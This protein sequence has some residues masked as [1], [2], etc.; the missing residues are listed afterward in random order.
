MFCVFFHLAECSPQLQQID[1][2]ETQ[3]RNTGNHTLAVSNYRNRNNPEHIDMQ[4]GFIKIELNNPEQY[5]QG[6]QISP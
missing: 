2:L 5:Q 6:L 4:F 3:I 1:V